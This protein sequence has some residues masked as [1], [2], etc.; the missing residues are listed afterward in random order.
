MFHLNNPIVKYVL[1]E[2][3]LEYINLI[4][5]GLAYFISKKISKEAKQRSKQQTEIN[6]LDNE[7]FECC[8]NTKERKKL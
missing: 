7:S 5:A 4:M 6:R 1:F 2:H 3:C 8:R